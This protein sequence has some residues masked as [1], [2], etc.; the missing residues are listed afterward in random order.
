MACPGR[1]GSWQR[2]C[3]CLAA[4]TSSTSNSAWSPLVLVA[5]GWAG[6]A[7]ENSHR[8]PASIALLHVVAEA[9]I[10]SEAVLAIH[11]G[12]VQLMLLISLLFYCVSSSTYEFLPQT[13]LVG[14][15]GCPSVR[16]LCRRQWSI[17]V[18]GW[19]VNSLEWCR[20]LL[21]T[22]SLSPNLVLVWSRDF[23]ELTP[24]LFEATTLWFAFPGSYY[25]HCLVFADL[26]IFSSCMYWQIQR[27]LDSGC[28]LHLRNTLVYTPKLPEQGQDMGGSGLRSGCSILLSKQQLLFPHAAP[29]PVFA[30]WTEIYSSPKRWLS[31]IPRLLYWAGVWIRELEKFSPARGS[32]RWQYWVIRCLQSGLGIFVPST[33]ISPAGSRVRTGFSCR[34]LISYNTLLGLQRVRFDPGPSSP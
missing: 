26:Y 4:C 30:V 17:Y 20:G 6:Y 14:V 10:E 11:L 25:L 34:D 13:R 22:M 27:C 31:S 8:V 2:V 15:Q 19:V 23:S 18:C 1:W 16:T 7:V 33:R 5:A 9:I 29:G 28:M 24:N 12:C 21:C 32:M 3:V